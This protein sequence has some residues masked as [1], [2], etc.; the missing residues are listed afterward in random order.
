MTGRQRYHDCLTASRFHLARSDDGIDSIIASLGDDVRLERNH[1]IERR[2]FIEQD[3][4]IHSF[5]SRE[6]VSAL[7]FGPNRAIR[8]LQAANRR[9]SVQSDDE[10]ISESPRRDEDVD[11]TRMQKV[12]NTIGKYDTAGESLSPPARFTHAKNFF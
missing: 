11:V 10:R 12:E 8:S 9:V 2:I 7:G 5:Q 1:E 3:H 4:G 6:N